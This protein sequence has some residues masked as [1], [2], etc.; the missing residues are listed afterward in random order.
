MSPKAWPYS[1]FFFIHEQTLWLC[2][3]M[4]SDIKMGCYH[5]VSSLMNNIYCAWT[6]LFAN[7]LPYQYRHPTLIG[8][9]HWIATR[10]ERS[11][12]KGWEHE[13]QG[14]ARQG[15]VGEWGRRISRPL[16]QEYH[17]PRL[18]FESLRCSPRPQIP[19]CLFLRFPPSRST[20]LSQVLSLIGF[21][22]K[23]FEC[24]IH[25]FW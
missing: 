4:K 15:A 14:M 8:S 21:Q 16:L 19:L 6:A 1:T 17:H 2:L 11:E 12:A 24:P 22:L 3:L 9:T 20:R 18:L 7:P 10:L 13:G 5:K 25:H 23:L